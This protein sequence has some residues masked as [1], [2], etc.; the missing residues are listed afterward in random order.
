MSNFEENY[1]KKH[2]RYSLIKSAVR[3]G[4]CLAVIL[5]PLGSIEANVAVLA[6]GFLVAEVL[7]VAEE[8][9]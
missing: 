8:M 4:S 6:I 9:I 5:V 3:I 7:G 2:R 1:K